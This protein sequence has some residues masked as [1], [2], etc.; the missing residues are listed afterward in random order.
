MKNRE[1]FVQYVERTR[2]CGAG[3]IDIAVQKGIHR[4]KSDR[5]DPRKLYRLAVACAVTAVL[6]LAVNLTPVKAAAEGLLRANSLVT[7]SGAVALQGRLNDA[8]NTMHKYLGGN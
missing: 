2:D 3:L 1:S 6:C 4:A 7:H 5:L 8:A